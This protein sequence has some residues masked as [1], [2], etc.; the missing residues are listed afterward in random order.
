MQANH[1]LDAQRASSGLQRH[2]LA[3]RQKDSSSRRE[4]CDGS[5]FRLVACAPVYKVLLPVW[6][7]QEAEGKMPCTQYSTKCFQNG[8][9]QVLSYTHLFIT[10]RTGD[11]VTPC[12]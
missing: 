5:L 2:G 7:V 10:G 3:W 4:D 11:Q 9:Y 8:R 1:L 12:C 6:R